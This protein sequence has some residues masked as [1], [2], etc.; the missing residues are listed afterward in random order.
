MVDRSARRSRRLRSDV[1]AIGLMVGGRPG[2][3]LGARQ[4]K[5]TSR[6]T[7][8]RLVRALPES[9]IETPAALGI[10]EFALRR[11]RRYCTIL[12]DGSAHQVIDLLEDPSADAQASWT[13]TFR[14][15][16]SCLARAGRS[17]VEMTSR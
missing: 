4:K 7:L 9:P 2:S 13:K 15:F 12:I 8:L 6:M 3:R 5:P 17:A 1:E 14:F 10:D 16:R 11:G